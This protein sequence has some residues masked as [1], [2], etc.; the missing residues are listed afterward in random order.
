MFSI[1]GEVENNGTQTASFVQLYATLYDSSNQVIGT[2]FA[3]AKP[4]TIE[5]GMK[6]P[7]EI[8]IS[9]SSVKDG[10][11]NTIPRMDI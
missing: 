3:Y 10:D 9:K 4:S 1:V 2:G 7:F 5:P 6:A 11:F 8:I